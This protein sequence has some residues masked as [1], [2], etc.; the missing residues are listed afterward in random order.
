MRRSQVS[1]VVILI[2]LRQEG[3]ISR[4]KLSSVTAHSAQKRLRLWSKRKAP[5]PV[6]QRALLTLHEYQM[7]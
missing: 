2:Q 6:E 1:K 4:E 7:L 3:F 5:C